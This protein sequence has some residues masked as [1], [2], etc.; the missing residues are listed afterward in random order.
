MFPYFILSLFLFLILTVGWKSIPVRFKRSVCISAIL[1]APISLA[2]YAFVPAYWDPIRIVP[3]Q[4]GPEDVI[5]SFSTGGIIWVFVILILS[6]KYNVIHNEMIVFKQYAG[7]LFF[8]II[9][10]FLMWL[11]RINV[12]L[13]TLIIIFMIGIWILIRKPDYMILS[14]TGALAFT[15]FYFCILKGAFVL[16][17][18]F[19][20]QWNTNGLIGIK[21]HGIPAEELMWA[22]ATGAVWPLI[23]AYLLN[24]QLERKILPQSKL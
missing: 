16:F 23:V 1:S 11:A 21:V 6:R 8:G 19:A 12:M 17:P 18:E 22:F 2:S 10:F 13:A 20:G 14:I 5:F 15:L 3:Y 24:V 4:I 9:M 7:L